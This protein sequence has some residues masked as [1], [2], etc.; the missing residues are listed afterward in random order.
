MTSL[1]HHTYSTAENKKRWKYHTT[2][3]KSITKT[4]YIYHRVKPY[5]LNSESSND[6]MDF[7]SFVAFSVLSPRIGKSD[8][9][10][11]CFRALFSEQ[12][13][14]DITHH[15]IAKTYLEFHFCCYCTISS[16]YFNFSSILKRTKI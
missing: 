5:T 2:V 3:I 4:R 12:A 10:S 13:E 9:V 8:E 11:D 7:A 14:C 15:F 1:V 6:S 16:F